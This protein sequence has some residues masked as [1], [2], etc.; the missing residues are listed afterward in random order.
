M[1]LP[2]N[3]LKVKKLIKLDQGNITPMLPSPN[4]EEFHGRNQKVR[5]YRRKIMPLWDL[6]LTKL[7]PS[8][9]FTTTSLPPILQAKQ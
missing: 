3:T 6:E 5:K 4:K 2:L 8:V 9:L 7:Q 1:N